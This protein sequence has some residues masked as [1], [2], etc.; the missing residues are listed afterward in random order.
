[1]F[2]PIFDLLFYTK[3]DNIMHP[4]RTFT[5]IPS[6][7]KKLAR[8][9]DL[10][11]NLWWSWNN[12]AIEL[13][14]QIDHELWD[15]THFNPVK[16]MNTLSQEK[17]NA[18]AD[19][20]GFLAQLERIAN[21]FDAYMK[22]K[23]WYEKH[24][25]DGSSKHIAYFSME[26][27][28]TDCL[29]I[30]SGG[31]GILAGDHLKS[32]SDL[33]LPLVGVGLLY[34]LGYFRQYLNVDGYQGE[35]YPTNDFYNMPIHLQR[36]TDGTPLTIDVQYPG[37][38]VVAQIWI[39]DVGRV[40]LVLLDTNIAQNAQA[41]QDICDRLYGGDLEM[42]IQQEI[43]LG[44]GGMY[45]LNALGMNPAVHHMNEG[46]AAFLA[47]ER[48]RQYKV[49]HG[50]SVEEAIEMSRAGN[51]FTTHTPVPAGIDKFPADMLKKYF[52]HYCEEFHFP[53]EKFLELGI[54]KP[55]DTTDNFSM[56]VF[57]LRCSS[58]TNGVS[59]LHGEVSRTMWQNVWPSVPEK[60][61]PIYHITNGIHHHT[62][63]S[64]DIAGL[65]DRY[66]GPNWRDDPAHLD[67]WS[68]VDNIPDE[69]LW[70]THERRRERLVAYARKRLK[71]QLERRGEPQS[72][73]EQSASAL[74]PEALTIGFARRFATYK[75][76]NLLFRNLER[77]VNIL[78][79]KDQPVQL[80]FAGKAHPKDVPGKDIILDIIHKVRDERLHNRVVFLEDYDVALARYMVRGVDVW[81]NTPRRPHE[82]SGTS[83]MKAAVNGVLNLSILDGWWDEGYIA[84]NGW[85]ICR[86]KLDVYENE[87]LQDKVE[88]DAIFD[89]L[90]KEIIP[91][92]YERGRDHIPHH[93]LAMMKQ[94]FKQHCPM[95]NTHRM[96]ADYTQNFYVPTEKRFHILADSN[97]EAG[98][99]L[100]HWKLNM[101]H[102]WTE[103][104]VNAIH[105][106]G[107]EHL[108]VNS[109]LNV[110]AEVH[111]GVLHAT[112][113]SVEIIQGLVDKNQHIIDWKIVP[114]A[115]TKSLD[116][117]NHLF[118]GAIVCK[119]SGLHG[120]G[121][122]VVPQHQ[123]MCS[124][125]DLGL[126]Y[127]AQ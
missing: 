7:P 32:A 31:L 115:H 92:F 76:G 88:A 126:I 75:R 124:P 83:G 96:V 67:V 81:L 127:W 6:I 49:Q 54:E 12:E 112:D 66:I 122:R 20:D 86:G 80:I 110:S 18:L 37:R 40:P 8:L 91:L 106:D 114:L 104:R 62:W 19:D 50:L 57:A 52:N 97:F 61:I 4:L 35:L 78:T 51:V 98:K 43:M 17:L 44:I 59:K 125:F 3:R 73:I 108:P 79:H 22:R 113:V 90:E 27:G 25:P 29:P 69:E 28:V 103:I 2:L 117:G 14:Y 74:D 85:A 23:T 70:R 118:E 38:K 111:L 55:W 13:F 120:I 26:F 109:P 45:A 46:H 15:E 99:K 89:L 72:E 34:Q 9:K 101:R 95:F 58:Y 41:D 60:E 87:E 24:F 36:H 121:L 33:G 116:N 107:Q 47:L 94:N 93:W 56:A 82:A 119:S 105:T 102:H 100:A 64:R 30:Y 63:I 39:A 10:A 16:M 53:F 65:F 123:A 1:M 5:V 68:R 42:R 11:Y 21:Q 48:I 71:M 84:G 77:L